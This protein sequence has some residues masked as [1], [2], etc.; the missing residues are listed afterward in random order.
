MPGAPAARLRNPL[1][2]FSFAVR[3]VFGLLVVFTVVG[4]GHAVVND[5]AYFLGVGTG[6]LSVFI[7]R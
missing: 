7:P 4:V 5:R 3:F 2:P 1:Q 6:R